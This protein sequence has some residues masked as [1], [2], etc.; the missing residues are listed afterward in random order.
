MSLVRLV[1]LGLLCHIEAARRGKEAAGVWDEG[2]DPEAYYVDEDFFSEKV[3]SV[4][5]PSS[6][7]SGPV[8]KTFFLEKKVELKS[9]R[10]S[11]TWM[12]ATFAD[13]STVQRLQNHGPQATETRPQTTHKRDR[14]AGHLGPAKE[15]RFR[16]THETVQKHKVMPP[17]G[18][19]GWTGPSME[20][21]PNFGVSNV[22]YGINV[23]GPNYYPDKPC[24][25]VDYT[26]PYYAK[27]IRPLMP[28]L[29]VGLQS[30]PM[31]FYS[32]GE[33]YPRNMEMFDHWASQGP[34]TYLSPNSAHGDA[35]GGKGG[36][37]K[38]KK[39]KK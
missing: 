1:L 28:E 19:I 36:G 30:P 32:D 35:G 16:S 8:G 9:P 26:Q 4:L 22:Y 7:M 14:S 21:C 6:L 12:E 24:G 13:K 10:G 18:G 3:P 39:G 23:A 38:G 29:Q 17:V 33:R 37:G 15:F 25:G 20:P 5:P 11:S 27:P 2:S 31:N 34:D